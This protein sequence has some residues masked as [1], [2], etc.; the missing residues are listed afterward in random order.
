VAPKATPPPKQARPR[1]TAAALFIGQSRPPIA[2]KN[3]D[4]DG[5]SKDKEPGLEAPE[6]FV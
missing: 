1:L 2:A 4:D 3:S 6:L 5:L